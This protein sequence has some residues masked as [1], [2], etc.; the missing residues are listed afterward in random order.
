MHIEFKWFN[1]TNLLNLPHIVCKEW[2]CFN[3][4]NFCIRIMIA[5]DGEFGSSGLE[6]NYA[7]FTFTQNIKFL[8]SEEST[9]PSMIK[10]KT[11]KIIHPH[12]V[13]LCMRN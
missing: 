1:L 8:L 7:F 12:K 2:N 13:Y 3:S 11:S 10:N 4:K 5:T 6:K 9:K